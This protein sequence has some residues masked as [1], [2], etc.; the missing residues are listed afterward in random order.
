M[1]REKFREAWKQQK[2]QFDTFVSQLDTVADHVALTQ[3]HSPV[4]S[5]LLSP[6]L[7]SAEELRTMAGEF[8][9]ALANAPPQEIGAK[10]KALQEKH[11]EARQLHEALA[12]ELQVL[13]Q[14]TGLFNIT[15]ETQS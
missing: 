15:L 12:R 7:R 14:Q 3:A 6:L 2:E 13:Y 11:T 5:A 10:L 1:D 9:D 8:D 4:P